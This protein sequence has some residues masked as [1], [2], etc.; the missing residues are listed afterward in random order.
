MYSNV[1]LFCVIL[2]L[3]LEANGCWKYTMLSTRILIYKFKTSIVQ[4]LSRYLFKKIITDLVAQSYLVTMNFFAVNLANIQQCFT[5]R[6]I[7][8]CNI[9]HSTS[10]EQRNIII[11][12]TEP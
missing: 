4:Q 3:T 6:S 2:C 9:L 7:G 5:E 1:V 10:T 11:F 12:D 8:S